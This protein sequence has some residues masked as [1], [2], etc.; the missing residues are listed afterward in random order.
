[1]RPYINDLTLTHLFLLLTA[2]SNHHQPPTTGSP[3]WPFGEQSDMFF[4]SPSLFVD[5]CVTEVANHATHQ[6]RPSLSLLL[7]KELSP[8]RRDRRR[9]GSGWQSDQRAKRQRKKKKKERRT[10][11]TKGTGGITSTTKLGKRM[12]DSEQSF[13]G[14]KEAKEKESEREAGVE[15]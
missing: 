7:M 10:A 13:S 2:T 8:P 15:F 14:H 1:M 4:L 3:S 12:K 6:L 5:T 9:T 11:N